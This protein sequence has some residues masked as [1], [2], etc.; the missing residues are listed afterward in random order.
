M[1]PELKCLCCAG[2]TLVLVLVVLVVIGWGLLIVASLD[3]EI[4]GNGPTTS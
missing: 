4:G 3:R 2:A 1:T